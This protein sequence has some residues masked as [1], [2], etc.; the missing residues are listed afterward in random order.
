MPDFSQVKL[1]TPRLRL[2]PLA[3]TDAEALLAIHADPE[4]M[5]Y[6]TIE[7][8]SSVDRAYALV[9]HFLKTM[10]AGDHLCLGI[11]PA[12][13]AAV[14]GTCTLFD[15]Y[16]TSR[17]AEVGF[18]LGRSAWR[19]GYMTEAL[20]ALLDYGFFSLNL[21]RVEADTD[22]RNLAAAVLLQRLGFV[23]EGLLRERWIVAGEKSDTALYGLLRSGWKPR[24]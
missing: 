18:V 12:G 23:R 17:R 24:Q 7:P 13:E 9:E 5:R 14:I 22:P 3:R 19:K 20:S 16:T 21:N 15:F 4:A 8:W 2:R 10:P 1:A 11:V 6:T